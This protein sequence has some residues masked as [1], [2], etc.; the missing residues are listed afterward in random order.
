MEG[1]Q[2]GMGCYATMHY[3]SNDSSK[4]KQVITGFD[5]RPSSDMHAAISHDRIVAV[6]LC[7]CSHRDLFPSRKAFYEMFYPETKVLPV[8][9]PTHFLINRTAATVQRH[10]SFASEVQSCQDRKP[11]QCKNDRHVRQKELQMICQNPCLLTY[12]M[13]QSPS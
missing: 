13:E 2:G 10:N 11:T 5:S 3:G 1:V 6:S 8:L 7:L 4:S 9:S 12:S